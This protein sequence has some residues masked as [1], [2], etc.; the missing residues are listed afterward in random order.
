MKERTVSSSSSDWPSAVIGKG[1][2]G[3]RQ[4]STSPVPKVACIAM[5]P[6]WRPISFTTPRPFGKPTASV[7]ATSMA[8]RACS[9]AVS[10][11]NVLSTRGISL[12]IVFGTRA[13]PIGSFLSRISAATFWAPRIVPSPPTTNMSPTSS[14]T[15]A[16][17]MAT[18]SCPP[19]DVPSVEPPSRCSVRTDSGVRG[20]HFDGSWKP[21]YPDGT[22]LTSVIPY[23]LC[24]QRT[25]SR[26]TVLTPGHSPPHVTMTARV[27]PTENFTSS[28]GPASTNAPWSTGH[29]SDV[30][31]T[32]T[33]AATAAS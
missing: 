18:V 13:T 33:R 10:N 9:T 3:M 5:K 25:S 20:R 26:T 29:S 4:R 24:R 2:S 31:D 28:L 30:P 11:P 14:W 32:S 19:R 1:T 16:S 7:W 12:S 6:E 23:W 17:T 8:F 27:V 22:P 15:S 21:R